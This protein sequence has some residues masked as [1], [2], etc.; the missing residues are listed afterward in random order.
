M[1]AN[2]DCLSREDGQRYDLDDMGRFA[3]LTV[4]EDVDDLTVALR[5][6][7]CG[8]ALKS[9][10]AETLFAAIRKAAA[11]EPVAADG[12][13]AKFVASMW[14]PATLAEAGSCIRP[15]RVARSEQQ[16]DRRTLF[17]GGEH[18][19]D[20]R[21]GTSCASSTS[22]VVLYAAGHDADRS[23]AATAPIFHETS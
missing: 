21:C 17:A 23:D 9:V 5:E 16:G 14:R 1:K 19:A 4:S 3:A 10:E 20:S 6:G 15:D 12:M 2:S 13:N 18:G 22:R 8:Y 11:G 7:A